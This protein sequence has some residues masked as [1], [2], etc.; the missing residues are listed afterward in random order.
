MLLVDLLMRTQPFEEETLTSSIKDLIIDTISKIKQPILAI[1]NSKTNEDLE[2]QN[3]LDFPK[4]DSTFYD[5][6]E[7]QAGG[8]GPPEPLETNPTCTNPPYPRP[9]FKF[10]SN[11]AANKPC[12]AADAIAVPG[13]QHPFPKHP[14]NLLP[15]FDSDSDVTPKDHIKKF[16]LSLKLMDV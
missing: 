1:A 14:K 6:L 5:F 8:S 12:L 15:K 4:G 3:F 10:L 9:N 13:A 11:M 2:F 7:A 16:M